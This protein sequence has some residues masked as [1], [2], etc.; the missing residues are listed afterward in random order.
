MLIDIKKSDEGMR[1]DRF[2]IRDFG[3]PQSLISK[4]TR[5]KRILINGQPSSINS[6]LVEGDVITLKDSIISAEKEVRRGEGFLSTAQIEKFKQNILYETEDFL[7]INKPSG[8]ATQGGTGIKYCV[9]E[10]LFHLNPEFRLVHRI[11]KETSGCLIVAKNR[12]TAAKLAKAF[13]E[14][15]IEKTYIAIAYGAPQDKEGYINFNLI[16]NS[17]TKNVE[18]SSEEGKESK[19]FYKVLERYLHYTKLE[20]NIETGRMHQIRVHLSL[21]GCKIVGDKRYGDTESELAKKVMPK[22]LLH[23]HK[24]KFEGCEVVAPLPDYFLDFKF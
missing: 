5:K 20:I 9:D 24:L 11:D 8:L 23:A 18:F 16:K 19:T 6:R 7:V 1:L 22:M 2:L 4:L 17:I 13:Q 21:I 15:M 14:K 10:F 12:I 3:V